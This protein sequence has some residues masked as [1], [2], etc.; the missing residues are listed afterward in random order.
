[1]C[2]PPVFSSRRFL[3]QKNPFG[4]HFCDPRLCV[5]HR[6][7]VYHGGIY[8]CKLPKLFKCFL[9][10]LPMLLNKDCL[11][12][13][14]LT[15]W[16]GTETKTTDFVSTS[17][18][19][20]FQKF[21]ACSPVYP[22]IHC[23]IHLPCYTPDSPG[24]TCPLTAGAVPALRSHRHSALKRSIAENC[25][26]ALHR[27]SVRCDKAAA[28]AYP[29]KP[30]QMRSGTMAENAVHPLFYGLACRYRKSSE[31]S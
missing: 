8:L 24:G 15:P 23:L 12:R 18:K 9:S 3:P 2:I 10:G 17:L 1:M 14:A 26:K 29:A 13:S 16:T 7:Q 4:Q 5:L 30:C 11:V 27:S 28:L 6:S 19:V 31:T 22:F 21:P 25:C 20:V